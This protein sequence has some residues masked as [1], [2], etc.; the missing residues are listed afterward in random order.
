MRS[1]KQET[2]IQYP[3][4]IDVYLY[5]VLVFESTFLRKLISLIHW[6]IYRKNIIKNFV[7]MWAFRETP[8]LHIYGNNITNV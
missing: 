1:R 8:L 3:Y 4:E 2:H 6:K 7:E 5:F